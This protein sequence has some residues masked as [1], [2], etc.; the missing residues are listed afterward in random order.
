MGRRSC[1]GANKRMLTLVGALL[2]AAGSSIAPAQPPLEIATESYG[3]KSVDAAG[4]RRALLE[5]TAGC[6]RRDD[7]VR[8]RHRESHDPGG[9]P[10]GWP[11]LE[12]ICWLPGASRFSRRQGLQLAVQLARRNQPEWRL[13][14]C[15]RLGK[16][17]GA[18]GRQEHGKGHDHRW[19]RRSEDTRTGLPRTWR[20]LLEALRYR[21][22]RLGAGPQDPRDGQ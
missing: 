1:R 15:R 18:E 10:A 8:Q 4:N 5:T 19:A 6:Q 14:L 12:K 9:E 21:G 13:P 17:R 22:I 2:A 20:P 11:G 3:P 16:L 7:R